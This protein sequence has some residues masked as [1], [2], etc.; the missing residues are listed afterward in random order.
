MKRKRFVL[1]DRDGTII[2]EKNYLSDPNGVELIPHAAPALRKLKELG[3]GLIVISNQAGV[4]RGYFNLKTL[5]AIH[6]R[7]KKILKNEGV[8][9]DGI[10][11]CPH[12]PEND[13]SC[14]KPKIG[15]VEKA[16]NE[17]NFD[18]K[19]CFVVGDKK[20]DIDLGK[21]IGTTTILV[22][23]GYGKQVEKEVTP[24]YTVNNLLAAAEIIKNKLTSSS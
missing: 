24:D 9:L 4:G 10:Y 5:E 16:A 1:L 14:R 23:T 2:V 3:L 6:Q 12:T 21:N 11:F 20:V 13:C 7:L 15:L 19:L 22:R 18:P 17:H 8:D